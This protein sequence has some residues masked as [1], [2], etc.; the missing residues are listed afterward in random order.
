MSIRSVASTRNFI[1]LSAP[2]LS[3]SAANTKSSAPSVAIK[4]PL[5]LAEPSR[6]ILASL[7]VPEMCKSALGELVPIPTL[8]LP[9]STNNMLALPLD[10]TRKSTSADD[11]FI[12]TAPSNVVVPVNVWLATSNAV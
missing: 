7:P 8:S 5:G 2:R 6:I 12:T 4:L 11:S 3:S 10:S 1:A 9:P